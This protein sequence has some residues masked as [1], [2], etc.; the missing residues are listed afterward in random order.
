MSGAP[1]GALPC[2]PGDTGVSVLQPRRDRL[3]Q[4]VWSRQSLGSWALGPDD[5]LKWG[6]HLA[7]SLPGLRTG[8]PPWERQRHLVISLKARIQQPRPK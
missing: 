7:P 4:S 3:T 6:R 8:Q 1:G 5:L 2:P